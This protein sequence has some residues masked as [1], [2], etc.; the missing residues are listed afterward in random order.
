MP[1]FI[2]LAD[3]DNSEDHYQQIIS[4]S[5]DKQVVVDTAKSFTSS[6]YSGLKNLNWIVIQTWVNNRLFSE[7]NL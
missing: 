4:V 5:T 3:I 7:V 1:I 2:A 6:S